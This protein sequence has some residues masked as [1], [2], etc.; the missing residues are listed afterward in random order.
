MLDWLGHPVTERYLEDIKSKIEDTKNYILNGG[1]EGNT[2]TQTG[3]R[4]SNLI[5]T[6]KVYEEVS[7][8]ILENILTEEEIND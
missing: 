6:I 3:E 7:E 5:S 1:A 2:N 4:Y 8:P